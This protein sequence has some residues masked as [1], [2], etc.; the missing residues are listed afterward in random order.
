MSQLPV[1]IPKSPNL[2]PVED[3]YRLRRE[4]IGFIEQMGSAKWTDYNLHDPGIT[5]LEAL[6][7]ALTDLGYRTGWHIRDLLTPETFGTD[8]HQPFFTAREIMTVNP[9]TTDDF[10]RLLIDLNGVRNAWMFC[11]EC[12]CDIVLY[13]WCDAKKQVHLGYQKPTDIPANQ[14]VK[15]QPRGLYEALL[16][17][18]SDP[19]L[20][21]LNNR[22]I[23][24]KF[25]LTV[26]G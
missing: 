4:G 17:L 3:F 19:E 26:D 8:T 21:D 23:N 6:C 12:A 13:A 15:V 20:G 9:W 1:T 22:K 11:K 7:Y 16:E 5:M 18:E 14:I 10:R 2:Q 25:T 24:Q